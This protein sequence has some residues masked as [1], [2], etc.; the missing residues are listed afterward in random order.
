MNK[1]TPRPWYPGRA[2]CSG[3][4]CIVGD[5]DT[6]VCYMPDKTIGYTLKP[7][8]AWLIAAAP[9]L[10]EALH[11]LINEANVFEAAPARLLNNARKAIAK[12]TGDA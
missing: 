8:D 1:H 2:L 6:I 4:E 7:D 12:A 3:Q 11:Q 5:G 10:L 9:D